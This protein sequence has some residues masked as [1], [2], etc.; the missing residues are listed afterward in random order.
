MRIKDLHEL[1]KVRDK[2]SFMYIEH[3]RVD[4]ETKAIAIHD[5]QGITP[6]PCAT[7]S[8]LMV[9][10][11][12]TITHAAVMTLADNGC[13]VAWCGE[14]GIRFYATGMG[15]TRHANNLLKQ[16]SLS[17]RRSTRLE[18]V[19]RL[20]GMRFPES[21]PET[22]TIEQIRGREGVRV[23]DAYANASRETG[24]PWVG[25]SYERNNWKATDRVN[26]ALS[27]A[28]SCLYGICHAAIIS[29]GYSPG[30]GFIHT[31]KQLSFVYDIADLYKVNLTIPVAFKT[32][33]E[34]SSNLEREVRYRC[35][36]SFAAG[37]LLKKIVADIDYALDVTPARDD[38]AEP[39]FDT[40]P[41][42]PGGLWDPNRGPVAGG[43]GYGGEPSADEIEDGGTDG[44]DDPGTG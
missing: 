39:D 18:V 14:Q 41:A 16:A 10:P 27:A 44:A 29:A 23:R 2:L 40:D 30:L 19:R 11:G 21:L 13:L 22:L 20:Y 5:Q 26:R 34:C 33:A 9:G 28:N 37:G 7:L 43:R 35:R 4:Q 38:A 25:R 3:C 12:T 36:D 17:S 42:A 15:E 32:T 24:V 6:V 1:P 8:L 31:G